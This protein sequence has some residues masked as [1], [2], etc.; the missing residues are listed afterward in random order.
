MNSWLGGLRQGLISL[1]IRQSPHHFT[2]WRFTRLHRDCSKQLRAVYQEYYSEHVSSFSESKYS[3]LVCALD[4]GM[5]VWELIST[6]CV[7]TTTLA[8]RK[9]AEW[10]R[11]QVERSTWS[12]GDQTFCSKGTQKVPI[13]WRDRQEQSGSTTGRTETKSKCGPGAVLNIHCRT[14]WPASRVKKAI[15]GR[16]DPVNRSDRK[17]G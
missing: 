3:K 15:D 8:A 6:V 1:M 12:V 4:C 16:E 2:P 7:S 13:L 11:L 10:K 5:M 14:W 9:R 17:G